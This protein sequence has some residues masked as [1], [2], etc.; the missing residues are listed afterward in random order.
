MIVPIFILALMIGVIL[1]TW[2]KNP[3]PAEKTL[4]I[5]VTLV[6]CIIAVT[7]LYFLIMKK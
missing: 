5:I 6:A 3:K 4:N 2:L 7:C 1:L